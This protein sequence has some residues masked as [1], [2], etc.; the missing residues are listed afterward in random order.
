VGRALP[1]SRLTTGRL[2]TRLEALL[3]DE[4][5]LARCQAV[6]GNFARDVGVETVITALE[7]LAQSVSREP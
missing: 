5:L 6:A 7:G 4:D 1:A 3:D 2:V